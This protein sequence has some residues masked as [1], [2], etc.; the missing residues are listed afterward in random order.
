MYVIPLYSQYSLFALLLFL[1]AGFLRVNHFLNFLLVFRFAI[2]R[3]TRILILPILKS[4]LISVE[5][6]FIQQHKPN[7]GF[8][9]FSFNLAYEHFFDF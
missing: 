6:S 2:L 5:H 1:V 9:Y 4:S 8:L 7:F 3:F